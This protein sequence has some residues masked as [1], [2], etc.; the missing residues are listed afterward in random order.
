MKYEE[1]GV[2]SYH[3]RA[4]FLFNFTSFVSQT[5]SE[6]PFGHSRFNNSLNYT[7]GYFGVVSY[8]SRVSLLFDFT[9]FISQTKSERH[10]LNMRPL[11]PKPSVLSQLN[12]A[13]IKLL[14]VILPYLISLAE[15]VI[16]Q[17]SPLKK[18]ILAIVLYFLY[19]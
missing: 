13:P 19:L 7:L 2:V 9:L 12:Y 16:C 8:H 4:L 6:Y 10:D 15:V 14:Y 11:G 3:T 5:T 17:Q 1:I 18:L